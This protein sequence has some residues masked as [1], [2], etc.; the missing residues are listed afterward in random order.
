[1][2]RVELR[3]ISV[4]DLKSVRQI[5]YSRPSNTSLIASDASLS[6]NVGR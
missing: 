1:M 2:R 3:M 5:H 4:S 6:A